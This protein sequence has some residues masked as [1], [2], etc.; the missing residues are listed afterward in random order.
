MIYI[1]IPFCRSFCNYCGFYSIITAKQEQERQNKYVERLCNEISDRRSEILLSYGNTD[2]IVDTLYI[3]GGTPSSIDISHIENIVHSINNVL[4][5]DTHQYDEFTIEMNPEDIVNKGESYLER[6]LNLGVNRVSMGIQSFDDKILSWMNRRHNVERAEKAYKLLRNVGFNNLSIDLIF[7]IPSLT[8]DAWQY[9]IDKA[10]DLSPEHISAY[11]LSIDENSVLA[12][13]LDKGLFQEANE[14]L[15]K[16]QYD[17]LCANLKKHGY[18][19]YEISNF[20]KPSYEAIHNSSYWT[21]ANYIGIG[22][23]AHSLIA[24]N[25][26]R[27]NTASLEYTA[28]YEHLTA[29]DIVLEN[30]MLSLRTSKGI[31]RAYLEKYS[32]K[33]KL[34]RYLKDNI[35]QKIG[36]NIRIAESHFFV[37]DQIIADIVL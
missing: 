17:I 5:E 34:D 32:D 18:E 31:D 20:A 8:L 14:D 9:S 2:D 6:L 4:E 21:R 37:S 26:R 33:N 24:N 7:G 11:Q 13:K 36:S 12:K 1:H 16:E 19:H 29:E 15:C 23:S 22:A 27:A 25:C 10:V 28:E 3:G 30:I 35:L